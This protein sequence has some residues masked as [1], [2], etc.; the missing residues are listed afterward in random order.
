MKFLLSVFLLL[1]AASLLSAQSRSSREE[2]QLRGSVRTIRVE[3]SRT[4]RHGVMG[5]RVPVQ[6]LVFDEKGNVLH[7]DLYESDGS[8]K[9]KLG[10]GY[11]YDDQ[12]RETKT[13]FYNAE[14][15]L[16]NTGVSVYDNKGRRTETTQINPNGS[17]NHIQAFFY[18]EKSNNVREAH[19]N[20]NGSPRNAIT[21]RY[22]ANGR[23]TE[24]I[25]IYSNG[26]LHH[27]NVL[28]YDAR[29]NQTN[30]TLFKSDGTVV[31]MRRSLSYD[32]RGNVKE[33]IKYGADGSVI[34]K[35]S[36]TFAFD[37]REN[38]IKRTTS[39]ELFKEGRS[40]TESEV[41]YHTITYF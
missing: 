38:W 23:V 6:T 10:W 3:A 8:L 11:V 24:E 34:S 25:F 5:P 33:V 17:V 26:A 19:R 14:G 7:Q 28:T 1:V 30:W 21:R 36:F 4:D 40:Q 37:E 12:G 2:W 16:T 39:R 29:G 15:A 32:D 22:D 13:Y 9:R 18:D 41:T 35:E 20:E 27:R 31:P